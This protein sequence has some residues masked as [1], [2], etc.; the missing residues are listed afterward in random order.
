VLIV[1]VIPVQQQGI[2]GQKRERNPFWKKKNRVKICLGKWKFSESL[3]KIIQGL[4]VCSTYNNKAKVKVKITIEQAAKAQMGSRYSSTLSLTS[5]LNGVGGQRHALAA[6]PPRKTRYPFYRWLGGPQ[7]RSGRV[8]T[9]SPLPGFD[10]RTVQPVASRY[11]DWAI[12]ALKCKNLNT[13]IMHIALQTKKETSL[14]QMKEM[15]MN[16][17]QQRLILYVKLIWKYLMG[18]RL[19]VISKCKNVFWSIPFRAFSYHQTLL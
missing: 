12:P 13:I 3:I 6:L 8:R 15:M 18:V 19:S 10:P 2:W 1:C 4:L 16:H 7:S 17:D 11:N 5:A 9:T 14:Q